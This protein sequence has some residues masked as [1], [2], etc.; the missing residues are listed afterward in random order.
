MSY[1]LEALKKSDAERKRGEV[2]TLSD[3]A[4]RPSPSTQTGTSPTAMIVAGVIGVVAVGGVSTWLMMG[5]DNTPQQAQQVAQQVAQQAPKPMPEPKPQPAPVPVPAPEPAP[6][7]EAQPEPEPAE[8]VAQP[9]PIP[10]PQVVSV[11][12]AEPAPA[13]Q[14]ETDVQPIPEPTVV[15]KPTPTLKSLPK[16]LP[17]S[18]TKRISTPKPRA[19]PALKSANAYVDRAWTSMDKGLYTQ[20]INDLDRAVAQEPAFA[21]AWFARGWALEKSGDEAGAITDY[22]RAI[23]TNPGHAFALFSRG[24][25]KLYG[26]NPR[27]AVVDFVRTQGVAE[28]ESFRLYSH[29]WLYLSRDRAG[30][31]AKARIKGDASNENLTPW[32]GPLLR[33]FMDTTSED[34]VHNAIEQGPRTMLK[35]RRATGYFFLGIAA[36]MF[37][38]KD[39]AQAYFERTLATGAVDFRQYDAAKRELDSLR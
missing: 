4:P 10:E 21:D 6:V 15:V 32:P 13:P 14:V 31:D 34:A 5:G 22:S 26:G 35:E 7:A 11:L 20:A 19:L 12:K 29:L 9:E 2:P 24:F 39:R 17:K 38:D 3:P 18:V 23:K 28:D 33:Y 8:P 37:G 36:K 25:L 27:D 1:I 16:S 30:Q